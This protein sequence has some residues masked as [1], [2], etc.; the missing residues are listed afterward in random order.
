MAGLRTG[1]DEE[2]R[3]LGDLPTPALAALLSGIDRRH[4]GAE[5][6]L[7]LSLDVGTLVPVTV[8]HEPDGSLSVLQGRPRPASWLPDSI[9]SGD[10]MKA[11]YGIAPSDFGEADFTAPYL[12]ALDKALSLLSEE[13]RAFISRVPIVREHKPLALLVDPMWSEHVAALYTQRKGVSRIELYDRMLDEDARLFCGSPEAPLQRSVW[14]IVHEFGHA[15]ADASPASALRDLSKDVSTYRKLE[16]ELAHAK[17][18]AEEGTFYVNKEEGEKLDEKFYHVEVSYERAQR[19]GRDGPV[20][21]AYK[22]AR[23]QRKGPTPYGATSLDESFAESFAMFHAD[24]AALRRIDE[25]AYDWFAQGGHLKAL[26][27]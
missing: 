18:G 13:E 8:L 20:L 14:H 9:P 11:R 22:R 15:I 21:P 23:S 12:V 2:L 5:L 25:D 24:P 7:L 26:A 4:R 17:P 10:E 3:R 1:T 27:E 19:I 16:N 6:D